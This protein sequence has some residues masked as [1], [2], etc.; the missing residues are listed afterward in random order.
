VFD[1]Y[2]E[3]FAQRAADYHHAMKLSPGA[4][5]AEFEAVLEPI[6]ERPAGLVCDMPSGGGYLAD[7]LGDAFDYI[8][9]DPATDFFV[10]WPRPLQRLLA[11]ITSVPLADGSVDYV[12]S[13]AGLHHEPSLPN[14][15]AEMRR[16][17][18]PGGRLVLADVAVDTRPAAFL[19]GFVAENCPLGHDGR[20]L[21][22]RTAPALAA[23]GLA[24]ADDRLVDVPWRFAD[25]HEAGEFCRHLFG[26]TT[27]DAAATAAA[28]DREIGFEMD[29]DGRPRLRWVLRRIVADAV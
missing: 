10:E 6:R 13:L 17:L 16:L 28:M 9:I 15:F 14:V 29:D 8:A 2:A 11:E 18:R 20:F 26:M 4:R 7:N 21:D 3:I 27:L 25:A 22:E 1:T 19:N 24:V 23:A 5:D 12:V